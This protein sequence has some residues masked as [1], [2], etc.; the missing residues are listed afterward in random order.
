MRYR[1]IALSQVDGAGAESIGR[2]LA[3]RLGF[4]YLSEAVVARV[5]ADQGLDTVTVAEAERRK[6]FFERL[7]YATAFG[8]VDGMANRASLSAADRTDPVLGLIRDAV[9]DAADRGEVVF[10]GHAASYACV[11][12][13]DVLRVCVTASLASRVSRVSAA[14][15]ISEKDARKLLRQSDAG[16]VS[17]LKRV[18]GV[19]SELPTHYDLVVNTD[20]LGSDAAVDA[21]VALVRAANQL[22]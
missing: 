3:E 2:G 19:D 20:R 13:P 18:Y 22:S 5:A 8:D 4:A 11:D 12:R 6:S 17:Y 14:Q 10:V 15:E 9:R 7:A 16:R 1:A 21:I